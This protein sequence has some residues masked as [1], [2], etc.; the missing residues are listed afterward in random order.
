MEI[1]KQINI[2][3]GKNFLADFL[4]IDINEYWRPDIHLDLNKPFLGKGVRS[5]NTERFGW[6]TIKKGS[7]KKIFAN[8]VLEHLSDLPVL[9]KTCLDLL[10]TGGLFEINVPYDLSLG[11]WQDPTH[12]R[13]FN[14]NSWLYYTDWFWYLGWTEARFVHNRNIA[15]NLSE[16]GRK[17]LNSVKNIEDIIRTPRAVDSMNVVLKKRTLDKNDLAQL[18]HFRGKQRQP[19]KP[20]NNE[21]SPLEETV[22]E[23]STPECQTASQKAAAPSINIKNIAGPGE[24]KK[25]QYCIWLVN[26]DDYENTPVFLELA[27]G[28]RSGFASLGYDAPIVTSEKDISG[29][30]IVLGGNLIPRLFLME[31]PENLILFNLEQVLLG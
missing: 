7:F 13:A 5:F 2:G 23:G 20:E 1:P 3:S 15:F 17:L 10:E 28:L 21:G 16:Y 19:L 31:L 12:I 4:N 26:P 14:E 6:V 9:M 25:Q 24:L 22:L 27:R 18:E 30:A 11:A 29:T 8:D